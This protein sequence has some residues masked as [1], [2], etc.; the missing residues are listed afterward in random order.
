[1]EES[2]MAA[3]EF[4]E[5]LAQAGFESGSVHIQEVRRAFVNECQPRPV[6]L[7]GVANVNVTL[8]NKL[9]D[10]SDEL[11]SLLRSRL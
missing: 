5:E 4:L 10:G 6:I 3:A 2:C 9:L 1:M 8:R 7:I 11:R